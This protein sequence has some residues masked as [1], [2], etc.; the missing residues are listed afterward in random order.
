MNNKFT[1]FIEH[2]TYRNESLKYPSYKISENNGKLKC[3]IMLDRNV[4]MYIDLS[5][6]S[7]LC[8]KNRT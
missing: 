4:H 7:F 8:Y 1:H 5:G 6:E 3:R 2:Y